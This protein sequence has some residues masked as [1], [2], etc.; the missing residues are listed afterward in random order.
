MAVSEARAAG[1]GIWSAFEDERVLTLDEVGAGTAL[2]PPFIYRKLI[3]A[4][5]AGVSVDEALRLAGRWVADRTSR[6]VYRPENWNRVPHAERVFFE[7]LGQ[8]EAQGFHRAR[9]E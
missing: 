4:T 6:R 2:N 3:D 9:G 5:I 7:R 1:R 8:A